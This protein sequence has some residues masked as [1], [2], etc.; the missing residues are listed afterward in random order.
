MDFRL[1]KLLGRNDQN[2]MSLLSKEI[3]QMVH[4]LSLLK[5]V[6]PKN[7]LVSLIDLNSIYIMERVK[8]QTEMVLGLYR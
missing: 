3:K 8:N 6:Y 5:K 7:I 2:S 1:V 4:L